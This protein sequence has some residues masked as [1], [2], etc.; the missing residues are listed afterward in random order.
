VSRLPDIMCPDGRRAWAFMA[1]VGGCIIFTIFAAVGVWISRDE[2]HYAFL[3]ALAA[4]GQ[5][6]LGMG[7]LGWV[8]GRRMMSRASRDGIEFDDRSTEGNAI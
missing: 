1:I 7:S 3:L 8:L 6:F 5:V 2:P 4:H